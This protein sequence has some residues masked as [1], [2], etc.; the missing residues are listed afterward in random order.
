MV[1]VLL[2]LGCVSLLLLCLPLGKKQTL[3]SHLLLLIWLLLLMLEFSGARWASGARIRLHLLATRWLM[4]VLGPIQ[5]RRHIHYPDYILLL[6]LFLVGPVRLSEDCSLCLSL[7]ALPL[8]AR[9][10]GVI[11]LRK[12]MPQCRCLLLFLVVKLLLALRLLLNMLLLE[13]ELLLCL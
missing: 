9:V 7:L 8:P 10:R 1:L 2:L 6:V 4:W 13:Y 12:L 5:S 11:R 3:R